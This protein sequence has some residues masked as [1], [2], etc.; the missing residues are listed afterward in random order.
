MWESGIQFYICVLQE[1][2]GVILF[3]IKN[4]GIKR[5]IWENLLRELIVSI[6][7]PR[8]CLNVKVLAF[9]L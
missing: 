4:I 3:H 6:K 5:I 9:D 7:K 1:N 8:V 2:Y